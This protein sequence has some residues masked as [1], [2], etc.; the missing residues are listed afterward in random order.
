LCASVRSN[1][2]RLVRIVRVTLAVRI[3]LLEFFG[4]HLEVM[5]RMA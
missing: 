5:Q 4:R 1:R 2:T 3:R